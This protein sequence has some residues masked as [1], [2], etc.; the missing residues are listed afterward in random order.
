MLDGRT[1]IAY[2]QLTCP[3]T[4]KRNGKAEICGIYVHSFYSYRLQWEGSRR[5]GAGTQLLDAAVK[6]IDS[7]NASAE[8]TIPAAARTL[9][10]RAGFVEVSAS[11][12]GYLMMIRAR[13]TER[14]RR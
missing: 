14:T 9:Y 10:E 5:P 12:T 8:A 1:V 2:I 3:E 11:I 6:Q 7:V 13:A 4:R